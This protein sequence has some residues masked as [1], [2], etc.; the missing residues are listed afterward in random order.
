MY[1]WR[2]EGGR[3]GGREGK[4]ERNAGKEAKG[5]KERKKERKKENEIFRFTTYQLSLRLVLFFSSPCL[6]VFVWGGLSREGRGE[7]GRYQ[8][9]SA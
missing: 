9:Y 3:E 1:S 4:K 7:V 2:G 5:K 8:Y 6:F